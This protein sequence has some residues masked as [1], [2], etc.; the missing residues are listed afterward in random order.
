MNHRVRNRTHGGVGGRRGDP[1]SYPIEEMLHPLNP[2]IS[3][4]SGKA[5]ITERRSEHRKNDGGQAIKA[6][7]L[8]LT[9]TS[10]IG[11]WMPLTV[12]TTG[13]N[14]EPRYLFLQLNEV[15]MTKHPNPGVRP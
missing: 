8:F 7:L 12:S 9:I 5:K 2:E 6:Q 15:Y 11:T 1:A 14:K 13:P 10:R 4:G 3:R